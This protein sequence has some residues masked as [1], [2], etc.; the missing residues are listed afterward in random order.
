MKKF[1]RILPLLFLVFLISC[2]RK[3]FM[4]VDEIPLPPEATQGTIDGRY[5]V[6]LDAATNTILAE[7]KKNYSTVNEKILFLPAD[8]DASKIFAFY[9]PKMSEKGFSKDENVPPQGKNYQI[10]VW[11]NDGWLGG[12]AAAVAVIDAGKDADG[13]MIKFLAIFQAE[14]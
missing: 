5:E 14:K 12:E 1:F 11:R 2:D 9:E 13:K 3:V 6:E 7:L 10:N 8:A 4:N